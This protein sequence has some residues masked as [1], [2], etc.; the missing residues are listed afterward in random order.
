M[1]TP[2]EAKRILPALIISQLSPLLSPLAQS[3]IDS[4]ALWA[5]QAVIYSLNSLLQS[6]I[7]DSPSRAT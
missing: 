6:C 1:G 7:I 2:R 3:D 5:R 4:A